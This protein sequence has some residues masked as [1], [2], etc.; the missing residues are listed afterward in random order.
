MFVKKVII[1]L[2]A[3]FLSMGT[4]AHDGTMAVSLNGYAC[5]KG[6]VLIDADSCVAT[7]SGVAVAEEINW[8]LC[9]KDT[10]GNVVWEKKLETKENGETSFRIKP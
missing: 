6:V 3:L 1:M 8:A 7:Y 10:L 5:E 9:M 4:K 2:A